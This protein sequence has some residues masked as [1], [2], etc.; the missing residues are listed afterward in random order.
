MK[1]KYLVFTGL[2]MLPLTLSGIG[3]LLALPPAIQGMTHL[4]YP[5][6]L[7]KFLGVAKVLGVLAILAGTFPRIKEWAYAGVVFNLV[8]AIYSHLCSHDGVKAIGPMATLIFAALSYV[9]WKKLT[10][11]SSEPKRGLSS[12][13]LNA[14]NL[15]SKAGVAATSRS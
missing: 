2:A 7:I 3:F 5:V 13:G 8:G 4:G 12:K 6:Y 10:V 9:Y 11:M 15:D 14:G 1:T